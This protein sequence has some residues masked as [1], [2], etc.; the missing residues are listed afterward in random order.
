M[1]YNTAITMT[2]GKAMNPSCI[3][4]FSA[5]YTIVGSTNLGTKVE[6]GTHLELVFVKKCANGCAWKRF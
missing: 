1:S 2:T 3:G 5:T 6:A 4:W